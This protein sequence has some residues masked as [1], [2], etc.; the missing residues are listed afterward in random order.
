[1]PALPQGADA[2]AEPALAAARPPPF[3]QE[4]KEVV[5]DIGMR[6]PWA[7][8][9]EGTDLD[10]RRRAY[11]APGQEPLGTDDEPCE[12][13]GVAV[14]RVA[15]ARAPLHVH[16]QVVLQVPSHPGEL[17][18]DRDGMVAQVVRRSDAGEHEQTMSSILALS[19]RCSS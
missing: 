5:L 13:P 11:S 1:M 4:G 19:F 18:G 14:A 3:E 10:V 2:H 9:R 16:F 17:M 12:R 15:P 6:G 8:A 7:R